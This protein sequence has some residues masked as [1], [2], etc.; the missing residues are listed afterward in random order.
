MVFLHL[1]LIGFAIVWNFIFYRP[2]DRKGVLL[3]LRGKGDKDVKCRDT[4]SSTCEI[5]NRKR[6][7][8]MESSMY[9]SPYLEE[10]T[11]ILSMGQ[12]LYMLDPLVPQT[13]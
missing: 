12:C 8:F 1:A 13:C 5:K 6:F 9:S 3:Q 4:F 2:Q 11:P 7:Y 10:I